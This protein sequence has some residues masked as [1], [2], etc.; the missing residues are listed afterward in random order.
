MTIQPT[1]QYKDT[2]IEFFISSLCL[3]FS[4]ICDNDDAYLENDH[5]L[6]SSEKHTC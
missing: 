5:R 6:E 4:D 1:F 2:A 3:P